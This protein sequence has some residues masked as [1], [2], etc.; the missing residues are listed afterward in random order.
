MMIIRFLCFE[1]KAPRSDV[2]PAKETNQIAL[3][4][5]ISEKQLR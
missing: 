5:Q 2:P 1:I 3:K 4:W